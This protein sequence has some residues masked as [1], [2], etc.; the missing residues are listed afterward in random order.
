M[1]KLLL[2]GL[3]WFTGCTGGLNLG[4]DGADSTAYGSSPFSSPMGDIVYGDDL[5]EA[6]AT[7]LIQ[8]LLTRVP[9]I[10]LVSFRGQTRLRLRSSPNAT[11]D[12]LYV[13]DGMTLSQDGFS[14]LRST[15]V[16]D[17]ERV[18]VLKRVSDTAMYGSRGGAGV[19]RI[20]TRRGLPDLAP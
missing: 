10:H 19:I 13:L 15:S 2:A 4:G 3:I 16:Q 7:D 9:G 18:E 5:R 11:D 17:V 6:G 14:V 12:M 20:W 8:A 1:S